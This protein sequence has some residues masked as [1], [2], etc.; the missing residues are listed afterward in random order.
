MSINTQHTTQQ[1]AREREQHNN[2]VYTPTDA[3]RAHEREAE[4]VDT[5]TPYQ[6]KDVI[7]RTKLMQH[8]ERANPIT[9]QYSDTGDRVTEQLIKNDPATLKQT[10]A[11]ILGDT[12]PITETMEYSNTPENATQLFA[13]FTDT[14]TGGDVNEAN[15]IETLRTH[16]KQ[17]FTNLNETAPHR[18]VM[19]ERARQHAYNQT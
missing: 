2:N 16:V 14:E 15:V 8:I 18:T 4:L 3:A 13:H 6:L 10:T 1:H 9:F 11:Q 17:A 7:A 12:H 19:R 5:L